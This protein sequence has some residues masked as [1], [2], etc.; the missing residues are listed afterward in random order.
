MPVIDQINCKLEKKTKAYKFAPSMFNKS[1][2]IKN[3][4]V[5]KDLNVIQIGI[6][7]SDT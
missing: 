2:L 4:S 1:L 6:D 3:Q 5:F 7:K